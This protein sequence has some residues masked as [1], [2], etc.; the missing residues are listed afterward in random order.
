M[1]PACLIA[2]SSEKSAEGNRAAELSLVTKASV[3]PP[4][5]G[6]VGLRS[7]KFADSVLPGDIGV[8]VRIDGDG[9]AQS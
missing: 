4:R 7:G 3:P 5:S 1:P 6:W 9:R 2:G 8:E